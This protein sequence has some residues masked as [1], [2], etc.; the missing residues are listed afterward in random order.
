MGVELER[1][2]YTTELRQSAVLFCDAFRT[3]IKPYSW[4][5]AKLV[6]EMAIRA[7]PTILLTS[8]RTPRVPGPSPLAL[9]PDD[10]V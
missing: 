7:T 5:A 6:T 10:T 2:L 3:E 9:T 8:T 1:A 4:S